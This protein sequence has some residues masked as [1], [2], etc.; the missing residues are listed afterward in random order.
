MKRQQPGHMVGKMH[1]TPARSSGRVPARAARVDEVPVWE[2][3]E[4]L[5]GQLHGALL[6]LSLPTVDLLNLWG[7]ALAERSRW[8]Q[9]DAEGLLE[10]P[11]SPGGRAEAWSQPQGDGYGRQPHSE[12]K[13]WK[14]LLQQAYQQTHRK[15]IPKDE[16]SYVVEAVESQ[17]K[18]TVQAPGLSS[19]FQGELSINKKQ[20][21]HAAAR[22]AIYAD[23]PK[24]AEVPEK[25]QK[26]TEPAENAMSAKMKL[27][28]MVQLLTGRSVVKEEIE[29]EIQELQVPGQRG[30]Q[31]VATVRLAALDDDSYEGEPASNKKQAEHLAAQAAVAAMAERVQPLEQ[32]RR[33]AKRRKTMEARRGAKKPS[34]AAGHPGPPAA[35]ERMAYG[36]V[37]AADEVKQEGW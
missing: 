20:A 13:N 14:G 32:E 25:V 36:R 1:V 15:V 10:W 28:E 9:L 24:Y 27:H 17:F 37:P 7:R 19:P 22:A 34:R 29:Y 16:I 35:F 23:F 12:Q 30:T 6:D 11:D 26:A 5:A 3:F 8:Q 21:E 4:D 18:A 33:E 31:Y 2:A